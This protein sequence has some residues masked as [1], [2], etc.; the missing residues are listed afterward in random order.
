MK[1]T[2]N[3]NQKLIDLSTPKVMGILNI[4]PDSFYAGSRVPKIEDSFKRA[5]AM[6]AAGATFLDVGGYSTRPNAE[7]I[8][9]SE[10]LARVLPIIKLI[11]KYFPDAIV[12]I[13]TFR[14]T[15]AR[16][17]VEAG[18]A[19]VNDISG[20]NLDSKMFETVAALAVPYVL[21]HSRGNPQTMAK[22]NDYDNLTV[23]IIFELQQKIAQLR[24]LGQ[25]DIIIDPGFGFAKN[26]TQ[27]FELFKNLEAFKIL[28]CPLLVGISRKSMIWRTLNIKA[29]DALNGTTALN[30]LALNKGAQILRVHDIKEAVEV[31]K[32]WSI[33][34]E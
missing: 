31:I 19:V 16:Q 4:T 34:N 20:G 27:N 33:L 11:T 13:D 12:S 29:E 21:M 23:D 30:A 26:A 32:L 8:P 17:A 18:A 14:A 6:L 22:L 24:T 5:E 7:D 3:I 2:L 25:K 15:V 1:K 10:E 28:N 9:E